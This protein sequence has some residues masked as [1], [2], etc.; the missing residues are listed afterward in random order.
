MSRPCERRSLN[1]PGCRESRG[2][3]YEKVSDG[4]VRLLRVTLTAAHHQVAGPIRSAQALWYDMVEFVALRPRR[5]AVSALT[6]IPVEHVGAKLPAEQIA[7]LI[8]FPRYFSVLH[9]LGV[10]TCRLYPDVPDGVEGAEPAHPCQRILQTGLN[11]GRKPALGSSS[12]VEAGLS[13]PESWTASP[14]Q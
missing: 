9:E 10:E 5:I 12:V 4:P 1:P 6:T 3:V 13:V 11:R 14:P 2:S 8:R 7:L